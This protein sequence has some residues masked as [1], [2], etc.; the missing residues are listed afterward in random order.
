M[1]TPLIS[2]LMSAYNAAATLEDTLQSLQAQTMNDF[3]VVAV[4]DGSTDATRQIL[5]TFVL[6]IAR[7]GLLFTGTPKIDVCASR[8]SVRR[9]GNRDPILG[10]E[11]VFLT[12]NGHRVSLNRNRS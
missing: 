6:F 3:E 11:I 7:K 8:P 12:Y 5:T 1:A 9:P 2:V 4:D 10:H